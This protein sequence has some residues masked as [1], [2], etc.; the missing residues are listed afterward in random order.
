VLCNFLLLFLSRLIRLM[1]A[2]RPCAPCLAPA[3]CPF[4]QG[5]LRPVAATVA[6]LKAT[7]ESTVSRRSCVWTRWNWCPDLALLRPRSLWPTW[8]LCK[9]IVRSAVR[10]WH[11]S[12]LMK[13]LGNR[14]RRVVCPPFLPDSHYFSSTKFHFSKFLA[15]VH[16]VFLIKTGPPWAYRRSKYEYIKNIS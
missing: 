6:D 2:R 1:R 3:P 9:L 16:D 10:Q 11:I 4:Q 5:L 15:N 8:I 7:A 12:E 13:R 14:L